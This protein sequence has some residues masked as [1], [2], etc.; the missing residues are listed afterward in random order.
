[1]QTNSFEISFVTEKLK[2]YKNIVIKYDTIFDS[3]ISCG[4]FINKSDLIY[5]DYIQENGE[6][7]SEHTI[8]S[9]ADVYTGALLI[10]KTDEKGNPLKGAIFKIAESKEKAIEGNFITDKDGNDI[11]AVSDEKGYVMFEGLKYENNTSYWIVEVQAPTYEEDGEIK[12]YNLLQK[13]IK[14][15]VDS[16]SHNYSEDTTIVINKKPFIL[17]VTGGKLSIYSS[18]LGLSIICS[19]IIIKKRKLKCEE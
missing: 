19:F 13:P 2:V 8:T 4:E 12:Y 9:Q 15:K 17:P 11:I 3:N 1:L 7:A 10:Y 6:S 14:V 18:I 5:T 16:K